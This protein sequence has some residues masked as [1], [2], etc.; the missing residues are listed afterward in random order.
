MSVS[1]KSR[2]QPIAATD[3]GLHFEETG[4]GNPLVFVPGFSAS[5]NDYASLRALLSQRYRVISIDLPG[6]GRSGPQPRNYTRSYL[7]DDAAT[8]AALV[9]SRVSVPVHIVG[10]SD[11]GEVGLLM[12]ALQPDIVR[13]VVTWG[14]AG[15]VDETHRDIASFFHN[16][17]D[18]KS[19]QSESYRAYL[20]D[21]YGAE[22]AR[23]MT[24]S[25][26]RAI[27]AII[28]DGGDISR[29]RAGQIRCAVLL[30]SGE[31]DAF[32]PKALIEEYA[33]RIPVAETVEIAGGGHDIHATHAEVFEQK[34]LGW[35]MSH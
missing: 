6:S 12:A 35:L 10:H 3:A 24:Q 32:A 11:G 33:S 30:V 2:S 34:V 21:A 25:L 28:D 7:E 23:A 9:R 19:E 14:A 16:V 15:S 18:D 13:S 20:V 22:N 8:I 27:G 1:T 29:S 5:F 26:A 31:H 17:I 4:T